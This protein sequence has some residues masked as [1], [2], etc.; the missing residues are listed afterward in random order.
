M[1]FR[2]NVLLRLCC[3]ESPGCNFLGLF[4]ISLF[5]FIFILFYF[6]FLSGRRVRD[7]MVF[8]F[9]STF[10]ISAYHN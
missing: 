5:Y 8:G 4:Y 2:F 7:R 3:F 1:L 9:I 10:A 6:I